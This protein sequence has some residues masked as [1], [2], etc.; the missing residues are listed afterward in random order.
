MLTVDLPIDELGELA[1]PLA[2]A[3]VDVDPARRADVDARIGSRRVAAFAPPFVYYISLVGV[4]G[5][6]PGAPVDPARLAAIREAARAPV[7]VGFGIRTPDDARA[8]VA[9]GADGIVV[10]SALVDRV[11]SGGVAA[12]VGQLAAAL[13][14][15]CIRV[16]AFAA[17]VACRAQPAGVTERAAAAPVATITVVGV[18]A[19]RDG[20]RR[21]PR[22]SSRRSSD[23][24]ARSRSSIA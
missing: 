9:A 5:A 2:R 21:S 11:A 22:V 14:R 3:G 20:E 8:F 23:S 4:T 24:S 15:S 6:R 7:A 10:G 16:V 19:R 18:A 1:A 12:L 17:L 13:G